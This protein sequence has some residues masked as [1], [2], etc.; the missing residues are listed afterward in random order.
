[1][2]SIDDAGG[3]FL[4]AGLGAHMTTPLVTA[5]HAVIVV[6]GAIVGSVAI[7]LL[8]VGIAAVQRWRRTRMQRHYRVM[9][10]AKAL[11]PGSRRVNLGFRPNTRRHVDGF[12]GVN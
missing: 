1:V 10:D 2:R 12:T 8:L 3:L 11:R 5:Y 6:C 9:V 7:V 4:L